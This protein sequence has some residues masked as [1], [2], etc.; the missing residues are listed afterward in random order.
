ME[1]QDAALAAL[2][3]STTERKPVT[4]LDRDLL[5]LRVIGEAMGKGRTWAQVGACLGMSGKECK[6]HVRHLAAR[7]NRELILAG[8]PSVHEEGPYE[9]ELGDCVTTAPVPYSM[10]IAPESVTSV[11]ERLGFGPEFLA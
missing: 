5:R 6:R 3:G 9:H 10:A 1:E 8:R 2:A 7:A 11:R 4:G